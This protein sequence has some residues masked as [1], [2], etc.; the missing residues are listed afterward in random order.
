MLT[1][2]KAYIEKYE[3][4]S[5]DDPLLLGVSGGPDSVC[6]THILKALHSKK[7]LTIAHVNH[8]I[9]GV[10][11]QRDARFVEKLAEKWGIPFV[12]TTVDTPSYAQHNKLSLEDAAR[13]IRF[14]FFEEIAEKRQINKVVL[15]HNA[16]DQAET[17]VMRF[18]RGSGLQGLAGIE[19]C[20]MMGQ[21]TLVRP[22]LTIWRE[23]IIRYLKAQSVDYRLDRTNQKPLYLRN[24]VRLKLFP[25]LKKYNPNLGP[26]LL[27]MAE[28]FLEEKNVLEQE[29]R[30]ML[31][32]IIRESTRQG[33]RLNKNKLYGLPL[34]LQRRVVRAAIEQVQGDLEGVSLL[35]IENFLQ[36]QLTTI[37]LDQRG[38][39]HTSKGRL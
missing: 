39:L 26:T 36:N 6:L 2:I 3:L 8:Q 19:P 15:A 29:T 14:Q 11:A 5:P 16:N 10:S 13:K 34:A 31:P 21:L 23:D 38:I 37:T 17:I 1:R 4:W 25:E 30:E 7:S 12:E 18:L 28:I 9:R 35:Y 33:L 20:K 24:K 27:R 32:D 22:L